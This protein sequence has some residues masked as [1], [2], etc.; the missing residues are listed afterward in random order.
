LKKKRCQEFSKAGATVIATARNVDKMAA[1]S[2]SIHKIALDVTSD[3]SVQLAVKQAMLLAGRIDILI[4]NAGVECCGKVYLRSSAPIHMGAST[5][6]SCRPTPRDTD[7][8]D[9]V[10]VPDQYVWTDSDDQGG[11]ATYD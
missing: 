11:R 2:G 4:N 1:L 5:H 8:D 9:V 6:S 3:E 7:G 10:Y